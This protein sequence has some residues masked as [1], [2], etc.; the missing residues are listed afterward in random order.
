MATGEQLRD[1]HSRL[2]ELQAVAVL[3][4]PRVLQHAGDQLAEP[5]LLVR[6][7]PQ[8]LPRVA[9]FGVMGKRR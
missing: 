1:K 6:N 9:V 7:S 5:L 3:L 4:C 2:M 8:A